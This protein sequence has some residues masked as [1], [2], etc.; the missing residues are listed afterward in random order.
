MAIKNT[1]LDIPGCTGFYSG[2]VRDVYE[3]GDRLAMVTTDRISAFDVIL[4]KAIPFKGQVLNQI[5]A[6][7]LQ[8]AE[9]I[10][11]VWLE[12]VPHPNVMVGKKCQ[13][14][15]VEMVIRAHLT[16]HAWR[17]YRD[18]KRLL[19]GVP[20][21]EGLKEHDRLPA[22]IITPTTKAAEGHDQDISA[23]KIIKQG[24]V[25]A[26]T[27]QKLARYTRALFE[28]GR[29]HARKMGLILA[30]TKYEFG[31]YRGKVFLIDEIH[32]PDSSRYFYADGF[33]ERQRKGEQQKQLSKEFVRQWLIGHGFQG[34][35][36]QQVPDMD[37]AFV[38]SVSERYIELYRQITGK[39]F[40]KFETNG[41]ET[42]KEAIKN[43]I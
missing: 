39:A 21:P 3:F 34:K 27:W 42:L 26:E 36:G 12:A 20:L 41:P 30:D 33:E 16:G 35:Q 9:E 29:L 13:P 25:Q 10:L 6:Y 43:S 8:R 15:K 14:F 38:N 17:E 18:G 4:P 40:D 7:F 23:N 24:L 1:R 28:M 2:K 22:P 32:T 11:P 31:E 5:A 37:N 19:C